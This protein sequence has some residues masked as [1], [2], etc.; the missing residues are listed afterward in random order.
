MSVRMIVFIVFAVAMFVGFLY[1]CWF[2]IYNDEWCG[3]E[4]IPR[5]CYALVVRVIIVCIVYFIFL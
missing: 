2:N 4:T 3:D 5:A 1:S